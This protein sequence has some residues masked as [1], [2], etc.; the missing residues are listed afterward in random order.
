MKSYFKKKKLNL[1]LY[2]NIVLHY[3]DLVTQYESVLTSSG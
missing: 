3:F 2:V 1:Y